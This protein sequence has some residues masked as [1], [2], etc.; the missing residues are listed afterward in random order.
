MFEENLMLR[1][2]LR[3]VRESLKVVA[4][5][6]KIQGENRHARELAKQKRSLAE[7]LPLRDVVSSI[8]FS[9]ILELIKGDRFSN[10]R[11]R[12]CLVILYITG[13]RVSNLLIFNV[14]HL[15]DLFKTGKVTIPLIKKGAAKHTIHLS[16]SGLSLLNKHKKSLSILCK[17]KTISNPVF[18]SQ[19]DLEKPISREH[20]DKELNNILVK[21][22]LKLGKHLRTHSFRASFIK[23]LLVSVPVDWV[24]EF[25]GHKDI[26]STLTSNRYLENRSE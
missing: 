4:E 15:K 5:E 14:K 11:R 2:E 10:C 6:S 12:L 17:N 23:D 13:L 20:L 19:L 16:D 8:E 3:E 22:S 18:S 25:V 9:S 24:Q 7:K 1:K 21:A 26:N